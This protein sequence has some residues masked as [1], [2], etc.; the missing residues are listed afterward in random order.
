MESR[1]RRKLNLVLLNATAVVTW[2]LQRGRL[3]DLTLWLLGFPIVLVVLNGLAYLGL[4]SRGLANRT[5]SD[6]SPKPPESD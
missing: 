4:R 5:D 6:S 1:D 3:R 2:A